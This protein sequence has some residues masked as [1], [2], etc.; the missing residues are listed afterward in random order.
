MNFIKR[1]IGYFRGDES[2]PVLIMIL[3]I[4]V[5]LFHFRR[6]ERRLIFAHALPGLAN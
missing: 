4:A 3:S 1:V 6:E 5:L 2:F